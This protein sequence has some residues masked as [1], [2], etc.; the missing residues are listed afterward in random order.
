MEDKEQLKAIK[1][2][3]AK[4]KAGKEK[5]LPHMNLTRSEYMKRVE[6]A[7]KDIRDNF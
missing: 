3:V 6:S 4:G 7:H 2:K 1:S 5:K